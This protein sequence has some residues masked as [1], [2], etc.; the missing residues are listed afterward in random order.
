VEGST[1]T[2]APTDAPAEEVPFDRAPVE[3]VPIDEV[4]AEERPTEE[5]STDEVALADARTARAPARAAPPTARTWRIVRVVSVD[6]VLPDQFPTVTLENTEGHGERL[7]FR[8]GTSEGVALAHAIG[9]T[10]A[11]RPLTHDL[12][13]ET[14]E[15][16]GIEVLAVRLTGRI[17]ST[18]FAE[19]VL[20]GPSGRAVLSCRPSDGICLALRQRVAAPVLCDE[21]LFSPGVD[22]LP[23]ELA[24]DGDTG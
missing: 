4:P 10:T 21:R 24:G 8:I 11:P 22:V 3:E 23:D 20:V 18:H 13:A 14:L 15:R 6:V 16:Y 5:R 19:L 2:D 17:G 1:E 7:A 9:G 12:F